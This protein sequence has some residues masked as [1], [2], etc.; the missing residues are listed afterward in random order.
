[1]YA[2]IRLAP[3]T[4]FRMKSIIISASTGRRQALPVTK[5]ELGGFKWPA[6]KGGFLMV[7][8]GPNQKLLLGHAGRPH[9]AAAF[10]SG[11]QAA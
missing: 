7:M 3:T 1:M 10:F 8:N 9:T 5:C 6:K 11:R 2:L 4:V